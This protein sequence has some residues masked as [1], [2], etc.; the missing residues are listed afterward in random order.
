MS[1]L[2]SLDKEFKS[3]KLHKRNPT[4]AAL[5]KLDS[6]RLA[7][8]LALTSTAEK[9]LRWTGAHY[10]LQSDKIGPQLAAKLSPKFH[11]IFMPKIHSPSGSITQNYKSIMERFHSFYSKLYQDECG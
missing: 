4:S 9:S 8:N 2:Q 1:G 6:A 3:L 10:Y 11:P 5:A 7:L